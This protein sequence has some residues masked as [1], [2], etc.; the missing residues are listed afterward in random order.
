MFFHE[1]IVIEPQNIWGQK[2]SDRHDRGYLISFCKEKVTY[3]IG[4]IWT[5]DI[6]DKAKR[7]RISMQQKY[8]SDT[9]DL[10]RRGN[11]SIRKRHHQ[12][13]IR[14]GKVKIDK[15]E[16]FLQEAENSYLVKKVGYFEHNSSHEK[17]KIKSHLG[18]HES[19]STLLLHNEMPHETDE[20]KKAKRETA[21][22]A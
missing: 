19:D 9:T 16:N 15:T 12:T 13:V 18:M 8:W 1:K 7:F 20:G 6:S 17:G 21:T 14:I 4:K 22:A 10:M 11:V 2:K 3:K 5:D